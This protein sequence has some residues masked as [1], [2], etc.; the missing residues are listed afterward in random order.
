M[1]RLLGFFMDGCPHCA[2]FK[3]CWEK[4]NENLARTTVEILT[5]ALYLDDRHTINPL[6]RQYAVT[7][8]PTV[9]VQRGERIVRVPVGF[10][11]EFNGSCQEEGGS[12]V[13][14][15]STPESEKITRAA[16][17]LLLMDDSLFDGAYEQRNDAS[18]L[19]CFLKT[20]VESRVR[21]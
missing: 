3:P 15:A 17:V 13:M 14:N 2:A 21:R 9:F 5:P 18:A 16:I 10:T 1:A 6:W 12:F 8:A 7:G 20:A 4:L 19:V 11:C